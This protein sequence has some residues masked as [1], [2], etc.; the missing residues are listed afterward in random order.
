MASWWD[1]FMPLPVWHSPAAADFSYLIAPVCDQASAVLWDWFYRAPAHTG[2]VSPSS[3][4]FRG[5]AAADFRAAIQSLPRSFELWVPDVQE[6]A[7]WSCSSLFKYFRA[8]ASSN[9]SGSRLSWDTSPW[10]HA[11]VCD[12]R[13]ANLELH[14]LSSRDCSQHSW[15]QMVITVDVWL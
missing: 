2:V 4:S 15:P 7:C 3:C 9:I 12:I 13:S 6:A 11:N 10:P 8:Q 5:L 1:S 14:Y